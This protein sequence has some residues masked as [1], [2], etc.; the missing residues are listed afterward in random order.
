MSDFKHFDSYTWHK[1]EVKDSDVV[2]ST[3]VRL[4]RNLKDYPFSPRL[5][6]TGVREII[7]K[8]RSVPELAEYEYTDFGSLSPEMAMSLAER[9]IV[10]LE[11]AAGKGV[12]GLLADP[13]SGVYIMLAEEDHIRLQC[14]MAGASLNEAYEKAMTLERAMDKHLD[15]AYSERFGYLT[16]CPTNLGTGMR[17]SVMLFLPAITAA[18]EIASLRNQLTKLGL[19]VRG[20]SGEGS[21]ADGC[22]YQVSNQITLGISEEETVKKLI[23]ITDSIVKRERELRGSVSGEQFL[24]L[25]DSVR[26]AMGIMQYAELMETR[27]LF[28]LYSKVR[29][30]AALGMTDSLSCEMLDGLLFSSMPATITAEVGDAVKTPLDRDAIRAAKA[31]ALTTA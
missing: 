13:D 17:A 31:R 4:A 18:K 26:R 2:V 8:V 23:S 27:E 11:F 21:G 24:K 5:D 3:R 14:L 9:H 16:H 30:G 10:S 28:E 19:T 15:F 6:E 20:M 22:L 25:R 1:K 7:G 12:R 29:L